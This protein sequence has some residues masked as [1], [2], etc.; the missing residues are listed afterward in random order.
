MLYEQ[1]NTHLYD[2]KGDEQEKQEEDLLSE[3]R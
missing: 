3:E 1:T 2:S